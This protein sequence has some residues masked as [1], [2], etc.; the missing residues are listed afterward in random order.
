MFVNYRI[1]KFSL[2]KCSKK[3]STKITLCAKYTR[4]YILQCFINLYVH[5]AK[6][7]VVQQ[8]K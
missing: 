1:S 2:S 3:N 4:V 6:E 5:K 8:L 7:D